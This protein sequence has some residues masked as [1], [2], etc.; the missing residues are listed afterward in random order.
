MTLGSVKRLPD[1]ESKPPRRSNDA[2]DPGP[3]WNPGNGLGFKLRGE[4]WA[5][6]KAGR[7]TKQASTGNLYDCI[8]ME[9]MTADDR[10]D[11]V[12]E[13]VLQV[14]PHQETGHLSWTPSCTL[15]RV[16]CVNVQVPSKGINVWGHDP[17]WSVVSLFHIKEATIQQLESKR[18]EWPS[19]LRLFERFCA[20]NCGSVDAPASLV[21]RLPD[22]RGWMESKTNF[23][24]I[25]KAIA[26]LTNEQECLE[27]SP[28]SLQKLVSKFNGTPAVITKSGR[29]TRGPQGEWLEI[30]VD[31]RLFNTL[32]KTTLQVNRKMLIYASVHVGF[33]IQ[34]AEDDDLPEGIIGDAHLHNVDFPLDAFRILAAAESKSRRPS[35]SGLPKEGRQNPSGLAES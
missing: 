10:V 24:G 15:P 2:L 22:G 33:L 9:I 21:D 16:I 27:G 13:K 6:N 29:I 11:C 23:S 4:S 34:A 32:A 19:A 25:F 5:K 3:S 31:M 18:E 12:L 28:A 8:N 26:V 1:A 35:S 17:G 30:A 14:P 20:G 7:K